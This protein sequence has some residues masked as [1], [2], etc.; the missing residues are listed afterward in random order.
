M[1]GW[2]RESEA[3]ALR[4][5]A[6]RVKQDTPVLVILRQVAYNRYRGWT[7]IEEWAM[8]EALGIQALTTRWQGI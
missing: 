3:F 6:E 8:L 5:P 4:V 1:T 7:I 2:G